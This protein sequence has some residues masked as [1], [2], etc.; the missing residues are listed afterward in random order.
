MR[1]IRADEVTYCAVMS[2]YQRASHW[3][4]CVMC[5]ESLRWQGLRQTLGRMARKLPKGHVEV[6]YGQFNECVERENQW[7][8]IVNL[9]SLP[10]RSS[11]A[12]N[13]ATSACAERW[14]LAL[15]TFTHDVVGCGAALNAL[16][17]RWAVALAL[18]PCGA[19]AVL[20]TAAAASCVERWAVALQLLEGHGH[21]GHG[22]DVRLSTAVIRRSAA[23]RRG[24]S[25]VRRRAASSGRWLCT[26]CLRCPWTPRRPIAP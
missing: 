17:L 20:R 24:W 19:S 13:V 5:L 6:N 11:V 14:R 8:T 22:H 2:C 7:N 21:G 12:R 10:L 9:G 15:A 23:P 18:L 25:Q 4:T 1:G 3:Q 26:W 16:G